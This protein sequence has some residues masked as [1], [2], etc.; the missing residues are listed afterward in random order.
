MP[1]EFDEMVIFKKIIRGILL[2]LIFAF[3]A[4][5]ALNFFIQAATSSLIYES[6]ERIPESKTAIVLGASVYSSG[7]LSPVLQE[8]IDSALILYRKGKV[9]QFLLS[10]DNRSDDY[11]E[12]DAMK[13]YLIC[14]NVPEEHIFTDRAGL[15]TYDS[16]YRSARIL[17]KEQAIVVT[18][19]YHLPRALFIA[20][21]LGLDYT[22]FS[23]G[24]VKPSSAGF[25]RR[26]KLANF[27]A[28]IEI[29]IKQRAAVTD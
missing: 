10:G 4:I 1:E 27:K 29:L 22:G 12:V 20:K 14:E 7:K 23:A 3:A 24:A 18:Q 13:N 26:E 19:E 21:N 5:W 11:N 8:R 16:M 2:L 28:A 17:R 9:K 6:A 25:V 15:D